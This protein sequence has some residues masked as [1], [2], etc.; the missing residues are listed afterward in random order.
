MHNNVNCGHPKRWGDES[1][2]GESPQKGK[3]RD[4]NVA[5][6]RERCNSEKGQIN[7]CIK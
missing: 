3:V 2:R 1:H 6:A 7:V 5:L 4:T